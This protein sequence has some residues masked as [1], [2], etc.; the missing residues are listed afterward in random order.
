M[1]VQDPLQPTMIYPMQTGEDRDKSAAYLASPVW[2]WAAA[3]ILIFLPVAGSMLHPVGMGEIE[4]L[5]TVEEGVIGR[6]SRA[7]EAPGLFARKRQS[8]AE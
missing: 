8:R 3:L 6:N 7:G 4:G 5:P 2:D 1:K